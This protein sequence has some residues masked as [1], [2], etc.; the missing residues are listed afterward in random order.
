[1]AF[2]ATSVVH[3][4][5][6]FRSGTFGGLMTED[7]HSVELLGGDSLAG[8]RIGELDRPGTSFVGHSGGDDTRVVRVRILEE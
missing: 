4:V 7:L 3:S 1:M 8:G 5:K 6:S 2:L